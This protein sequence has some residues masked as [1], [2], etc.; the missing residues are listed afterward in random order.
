MTRTRNQRSGALLLV[1]A[2]LALLTPAP[3]PAQPVATLEGHTGEVNKVVFSPD[4]RRLAS[5]S[6]DQTVKVWNAQTGQEALS[7]TGHTKYV[8]TLAFSPHG[9]RILSRSADHTAKL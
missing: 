6:W 1:I 4:G 3:L 5:G 8:S 2:G 9:R 7:L